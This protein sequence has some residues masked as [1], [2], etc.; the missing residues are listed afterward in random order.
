MIHFIGAGGSGKSTTGRM[1]AKFLG[2]PFLNLDRLFD[3]EHDNIDDFIAR[4]GYAAYAAANVETYLQVNAN[5][6][7]VFAV[8]SGFMTHPDTIHV[9]LPAIR[10]C[11]VARPSTF[12]LLPS[13]DLE[14]CVA[15]KLR[16]QR[17]RRLPRR[18]SDSREDEVIRERFQVYVGLPLRVIT[19]MDFPRS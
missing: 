7:G 18:R 1:V 3:K 17:T 10:R 9:S 19:T 12:V 5:E 14:L 16:R 6:L 13:I 2:W 4:Q 8:S 11:V 15:E